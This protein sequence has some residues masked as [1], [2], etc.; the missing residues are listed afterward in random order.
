LLTCIVGIVVIYPGS[1]GCLK[2]VAVPV[3]VEPES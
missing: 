3:D 1:I 2:E